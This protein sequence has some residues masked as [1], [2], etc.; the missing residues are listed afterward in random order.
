MEGQDANKLMR[1]F[2][3]LCNQNYGHSSDLERTDFL[4]AYMPEGDKEYTGI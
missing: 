2:Q 4:E 1:K 3:I